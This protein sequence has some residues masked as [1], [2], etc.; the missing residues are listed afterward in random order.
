MAESFI[1]SN[2]SFLEAFEKSWSCY[3]GYITHVSICN[4]TADTVLLTYLNICRIGT[5]ELILFPFKLIANLQ[6]A[7]GNETRFYV[8]MYTIQCSPWWHNG[9]SQQHYWATFKVN[10][11]DVLASVKLSSHD[12]A[13]LE[14]WGL[15]TKYDNTGEKKKI[16]TLLHKC[17]HFR[18]SYESYNCKI[19]CKGI[20]VHIYTHADSLSEIFR[21]LG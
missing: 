7:Y 17:T 15:K 11:G 13:V 19:N 9:G 12:L 10:K 18:V 5:N 2:F 14:L 4:G 20:H 1:Q 16:N 21:H 3:I 6:S 8:K